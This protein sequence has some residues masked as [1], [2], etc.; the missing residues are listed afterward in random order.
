MVSI[1][2]CKTVLTACNRRLVLYAKKDMFLKGLIACPIP[3]IPTLAALET[4]WTAARRI[5][6]QQP[7]N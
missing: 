5:L 1:V 4:V 3:T 2:N 6:Q 7:L